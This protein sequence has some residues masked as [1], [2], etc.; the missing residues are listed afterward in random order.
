MAA[1]RFY[2]EG[3][4]TEDRLQ[5]KQVFTARFGT[6]T[7]LSPALWRYLELCGHHTQQRCE[8]FLVFFQY[9]ARMAHVAK[10]D[11]KTQPVRW[12][13][14]LANNGQVEF[15][16]RVVPDEFIL[17]SGQGKQAA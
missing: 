6:L 14:M 10:L 15:T 13:A 1:T 12:F 7:I 3:V 8:R 5:L 2:D 17:G 4:E 9:H 11:G 16:E